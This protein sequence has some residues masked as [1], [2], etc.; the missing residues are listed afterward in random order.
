MDSSVRENISGFSNRIFTY[1][2]FFPGRSLSRLNASGRASDG[3]YVS[4]LHIDE[5]GDDGLFG[6]S[7]L[8]P[9]GVEFATEKEILGLHGFD[10]EATD[11][12]KLKFWL[13]NHRAPV[14]A[15]EK[16]LDAAKL[17]ANSTVEEFEVVR[18]SNEMRRISTVAN[19]LIATPNK[20]AATGDGGFLITNDHS[21]KGEYVPYDFYRE[22][23]S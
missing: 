13:I 6:L 12:S 10:V 20:L 4:I 23:F 22:F 2:Y 11:D 1:A 19:G 3:D 21:G 14:D 7:Q 5:P 18:G 17:G 8:K 16:L 9:I 15:N